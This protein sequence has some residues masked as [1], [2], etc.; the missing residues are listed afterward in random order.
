[1]S[2]RS[3]HRA[4]GHL[5][6]VGKFSRHPRVP[7]RLRTR[8]AFHFLNELRCDQ[9]ARSTLNGYLTGTGACATQINSCNIVVATDPALAQPDIQLLSPTRCEWT[10][11]IWWPVHQALGQDHLITAD[12]IVLHPRPRPASSLRSADPRDP[13]ASGSICFAPRPTSL[14]ARREYGSREDLP[15]ASAVRSRPQVECRPALADQ[16][17][18]RS[19][20]VHPGPRRRDA[21]SGGTCAMGLDSSAVLDPQ[22]RVRGIAGLRVVDASVMPTVPGGNTNGAVMMIAEKAAD[23]ILGVNL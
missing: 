17:R 16:S 23:L 8:D 10:R 20:C 11:K 19:Q 21:A 13:P 3:R 1:M 18:R 22:L 9:I 2:W 7:D 5:P 12:A 15:D 14:T 4:Q 6:G